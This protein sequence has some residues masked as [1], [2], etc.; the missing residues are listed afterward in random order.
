MKPALDS[1]ASKSVGISEKEITI[2]LKHDGKAETFKLAAKPQKSDA[3]GTAS[4]FIVKDK[5]FM[6]DL[7]H[8]GS[9]PVLSLKIGGKSF[10]AKLTLAHT[11]H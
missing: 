6:E 9:D 4:M 2:A 8:K 3:A 1:T 7:H 5:E 11:D 10:S